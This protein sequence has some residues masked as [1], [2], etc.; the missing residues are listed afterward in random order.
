M[1]TDELAEI[2]DVAGVAEKS[3]LNAIDVK[4]SL[5]DLKVIY[6]NYLLSTKIY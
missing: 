3:A 4:K 5:I 6:R 2:V 1:A